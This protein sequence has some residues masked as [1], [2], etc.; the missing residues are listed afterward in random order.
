[1]VLHFYHKRPLLLISE[2]LLVRICC[3]RK[4]ASRLAILRTV[5]L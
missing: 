1:L 3:R 4:A 2:A 5:N